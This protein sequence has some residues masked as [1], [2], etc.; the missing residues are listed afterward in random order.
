MSIETPT[1]LENE[2]GK[3][4]HSAAILQVL[5]AEAPHHKM[6]FSPGLQPKG[7]PAK[8]RRLKK[9]FYYLV[10]V[11]LLVRTRS[12]SEGNVGA[13][14]I[15]SALALVESLIVTKTS[16][17]RIVLFACPAKKY[18]LVQIA[19]GHFGRGGLSKGK[20][21]QGGGTLKQAN[22]KYSNGPISPLNFPNEPPIVLIFAGAVAK[23]AEP[24][25]LSVASR[26]DSQRNSGRHAGAGP[27]IAGHSRACAAL[28]FI[29]WNRAHGDRRPQSGGLPLWNSRFRHIRLRSLA[30]SAFA[31]QRAGIKTTANKDRST[32][33][34]LRFWQAP[35]ALPILHKPYQSRFPHNLACSQPLSH[36]SLGTSGC[37]GIASRLLQRF[38]GLRGK[39]I[40]AVAH[41]T[42]AIS[43]RIER[44]E[45]RTRTNCHRIRHSRSS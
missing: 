28:R 27:A 43:P 37:A 31:K 29:A 25:F 41:C 20:C 8:H 39:R 10:H 22:S 24:A 1:L 45:M 6:L 33:Q 13:R 15:R 19:L 34:A 30:G 40:F 2:G 16:M 12:T 14:I 44:S 3:R 17:L 7:K 35:Q 5:L 9:P 23:N 36:D 11:P 4:F 21:G 42:G 38:A 26:F 32:T 18:H